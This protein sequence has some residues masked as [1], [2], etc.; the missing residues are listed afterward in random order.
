MACLHWLRSTRMPLDMSS[1]PLSVLCHIS[2]ALS[3]T[4]GLWPW[5]GPVLLLL[6]R[7][8]G[9]TGKGSC[10]PATSPLLLNRMGRHRLSSWSRL[11]FWKCVTREVLP[12]TAPQNLD[13]FNGTFALTHGHGHTHMHSTMHTCA[14]LATYLNDASHCCILLM[15]AMLAIRQL[16]AETATGANAARRKQRQA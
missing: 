5:C 9:P 2:G 12:Y 13:I 3:C 11:L 8:L 7:M 14:S 1:L 6:T 10:S 16:L 4:S 15:E